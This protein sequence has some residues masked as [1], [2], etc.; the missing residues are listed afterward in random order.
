MFK[1]IAIAGSMVLAGMG[2]AHA[3]EGGGSIFPHGVENFM[4][5]A[6]PPPGLYGMVFGSSYTADRV[7]DGNGESLNVPG[8]K[9]TA[10]VI[11]PRLVWRPN[12]QVL[13]GDVVAHVIA[14]LVDLKVNTPGGSQHK[15]GL[16]DLTVGVGLGY[17]HSES[18][19]S[20]VA[21]DAY[22]PTGGY[23]KGDIANI[24]RNYGAIEPVFALSY[25]NRTGFNGDVRV[26]YII[27][28][29][30]TATD[31][32]SGNELHFDYAAGWGLGN[33][34]TLGVG[35]YVKQQVALD[36]QVGV[37]LANSKTSGVAIGPNVKY[38]S[39]KGWFVTVK[40]QNESNVKN[41][42]QGNALWLKAVFPL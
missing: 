14:P 3:T 24:G 39:G 27:N 28:Q 42:T 30:N 32:K 6:L 17:H 5:G 23:T 34:W 33:G 8:F 7:N 21:L 20:V 1:R 22:L 13:G 16:G 38:D 37:A 36:K 41:G 11:A 15:S 25:I 4:A 12:M 10:N 40:W 31:Y 35:G 26:G 29:R 9:V 2:C 19:H 18:L